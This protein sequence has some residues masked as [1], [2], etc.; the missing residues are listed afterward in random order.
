MKA[1][2]MEI[3]SMQTALPSGVYVRYASSR[4]DVLKCLIVG[5][6][7]TPYENGLFEFDI[8]CPA[9]Y[10]ASPPKV[11]FKTTG[12]GQAHFNPNL[13]RD[14]KVCLSLLGTWSGEPWR[15]NVSTMLQIFVSLQSMVLCEEP[16]CNEP[17]REHHVGS[18]ASFKYNHN[19]R[20]L[21]VEYAL[22]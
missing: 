17:G 9:N 2:V 14:G 18:E 7:G 11:K 8:I 3:T 15:P 16:W 13:Y 4:V 22:L 21:T 19:I 5:P 20:H 12:G 1:L 10:P 6:M